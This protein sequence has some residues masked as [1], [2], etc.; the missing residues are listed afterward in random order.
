MPEKGFIPLYRPWRLWKLMQ[1]RTICWRY[2]NGFRL[3]FY[4]GKGSEAMLAFSGFEG[5]FNEEVNR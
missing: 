2:I 1:A 3:S 4:L 5:G